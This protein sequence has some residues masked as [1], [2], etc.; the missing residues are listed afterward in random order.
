[1]LDEIISNDPRETQGIGGDNMTVMVVDLK[2]GARSY[3][4]KSAE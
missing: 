2:P 3:R 1:M 4:L